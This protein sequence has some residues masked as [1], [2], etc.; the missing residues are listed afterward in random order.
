MSIIPP[1]EDFPKIS[2]FSRDIVIT[3]KID[4]TNAQ[5]TVCEDGSVVA[6]SRSRYLTPQDDNFGFAKWVEGN[7]EELKLL[8]VG[9]HFGEWWGNGIQ[10]G[11]GL[12]K[13]EKRFSLFNVHRWGYPRPVC[14][15]IVPTLYV[16]KFRTDDIDFWLEALKMGGSKCA[17]GFMNPEGIVIYHTAA[18]VLFKKTI[19]KDDEY[20][21]KEISK[22]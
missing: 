13:G 8:G 21:S 15:G 3:E 6:G 22:S 12:A 10:R 11:Y 18:N 4:G 19:Y 17:P 14:C 2:R 20:K 16:G 7:K 9:R 1:F 5:V